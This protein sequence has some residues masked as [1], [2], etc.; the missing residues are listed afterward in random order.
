MNT[1]EYEAF[2]KGML[3]ISM[4]YDKSRDNKERF[5]AGDVADFSYMHAMEQSLDDVLK[6]KQ[7]VNGYYA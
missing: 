2:V 7:D 6:A 4:I 3:F 1:E 5:T